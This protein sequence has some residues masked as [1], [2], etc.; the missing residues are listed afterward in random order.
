VAPRA[1]RDREERG[2]DVYLPPH[3]NCLVEVVDDYGDGEHDG[4]KFYEKFKLSRV[5]K[6]K[7]E[8][9]LEVAAWEGR[10]GTKFASCM[11][12]KYG[13]KFWDN[14][15]EFDPDDFDGW[16][17]NAGLEPRKAPG[18]SDSAATGTQIDYKSMH[19]IPKPKK[20]KNTKKTADEKF[21]DK[22]AKDLSEDDERDMYGALGS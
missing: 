6:D 12:S 5:D 21:I 2:W 18:A 13:P 11:E 3:L 16:E 4:K 7:V 9:D 1:K 19:A 15:A 20:K 22:A 14:G 8:S 17:F 10:P